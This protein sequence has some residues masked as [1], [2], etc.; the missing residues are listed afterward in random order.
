MKIVWNSKR[1]YLKIWI[2][3]MQNPRRKSDT[4][5]HCLMAILA[6][7]VHMMVFWSSIHFQ[8]LILAIWFWYSSSMSAG[9]RFNVNWMEGFIWVSVNVSVTVSLE[10]C[11]VFKRFY[12]VFNLID[13][14][15]KKILSSQSLSYSNTTETLFL[16][17]LVWICS[18]AI[19][20]IMIY[21][22]VLW[23]IRLIRSSWIE[24]LI[25]F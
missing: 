5:L 24:L 13:L 11:F 10:F 20:S 21:S 22:M 8:R 17:D 9:P 19:N 12:F 16:F 1:L 3:I 23:I 25:L 14:Q 2:Y 6:N 15:K 18:N 4:E 7:L